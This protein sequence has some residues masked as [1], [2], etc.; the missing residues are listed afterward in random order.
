MMS[1]AVNNFLKLF[2]AV[3][4]SRY[5]T[6]KMHWLLHFARAARRWGILVACFVLERFHRNPKAYATEMK[7]RSGNA[8]LNLL[9]EVI[10][11]TLGRLKPANALNFKVGLLMPRKPY[12]EENAL[13]NAVMEID[14]T[15]ALSCFV[16][17]VSRFN[18]FGTCSKGDVVLHR[19]PGGFRAALVMLHMEIDGEQLTIVNSWTLKSIDRDANYS[20]WIREINP[21]IILTEDILDTVIYTILKENCAG[22]LLP[23]EFC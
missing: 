11:N 23:F 5:L 18:D 16:G 2:V 22:V 8:G 14:V 15:Y 9:K 10:C 1:N 13:I 21:E 20:V 3:W 4:G 17:L 12:K 7:N 19:I 6:P